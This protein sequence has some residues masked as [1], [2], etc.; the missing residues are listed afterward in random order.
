[1]SK[2]EEFIRDYTKGCSN[3]LTYGGY[4]EWLTPEQALCA[5]EMAREEIIKKAM[6][7]IEYNGKNGGCIYDGWKDDFQKEMKE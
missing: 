2:A 1:M 3:E 6:E 7:W 4:H 5:V